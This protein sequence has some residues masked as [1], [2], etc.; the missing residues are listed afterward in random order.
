MENQWTASNRYESAAK[1]KLKNYK[2]VDDEGK[3]HKLFEEAKSGKNKGKLTIGGK[4]DKGTFGK[5]WKRI[6]NG[7]IKIQ[8]IKDENLQTAL[9]QAM[10]LYNKALDASDAVIELRN[11]IRE[12]AQQKLDNIIDDYTHLTDFV[13]SEHDLTEANITLLEKQTGF[14]KRNGKVAKDIE[15]QKVKYYQ[16]QAEYQNE[17]IALRRGEL[18]DYKA[19]IK[20]QLKS[21]EMR[22]GDESWVDAQKHMK[23]LNTEIANAK[24]NIADLNTKIRESNWSNFQNAI[25]ILEHLDNQLNSTIGLFSDLEAFSK[26]GK[27]NNNG[28]NQINVNAQLMANAREEVA[29]YT[30]AIKKLKTELKNQTITQAEYDEEMRDYTEK[31]LAAVTSV[32]KYRD[33]IIDLIKNGL[34]K[35]IEAFSEL[36]SKRKEDLQRQKDANDYAKNVRDQTKN[37]NKLRQQISALSGDTTQATQARI[38]QLQAQLAEQEENLIETRKDHEYDVFTK[39]LDDEDKAFKESQEDRIRELETSLQAQDKAIKDALQ[40]T[41]TDYSTTYSFLKQLSEEYGIKLESDITNPWKNAK[42]AAEEYERSVN[43]IAESES[44]IKTGGQVKNTG[45]TKQ[46]GLKLTKNQT[47]SKDQNILA[48]NNYTGSSKNKPKGATAKQIAEATQKFYNK[49]STKD[50][51]INSS[52]GSQSKNGGK[53]GT[54]TGASNQKAVVDG[55]KNLKIALEKAQ[56]TYNNSDAELKKIQHNIENASV[57]MANTN[58]QREREKFQQIIDE[59]RIRLAGV[60]EKRDRDKAALNA[61]QSKFNN[62][63]NQLSAVKDINAKISSAKEAKKAAQSTYDTAN[64]TYKDL[65]DQY[66]SAMAKAAKAKGAKKSRLLASAGQIKKDLDAAKSQRSS[67]KKALNA[68]ISDL[69]KLNIQKG[70][71]INKALGLPTTDDIKVAVEEG[72]AALQHQLE[73]ES[74]PTKRSEIITAI[75]TVASNIINEMKSMTLTSKSGGGSS[76][77]SNKTGNSTGGNQTKSN[78]TANTL[79]GIIN[80]G[81]KHGKTLTAAE[82]KNSALWKYIVQNYQRTPTTAMYRSLAKALGVSVPSTGNLNAKQRSAILTKLKKAG[83]KS[84]SKSVTRPGVYLTDEQGLGTEAIITKSG[85][86]RQLGEGTMVFNKQQKETLWEMSKL[87]AQDLY[88]KMGEHTVPH[89]NVTTIAPS[90][91]CHYD[92]LLTVNGNVDKD[93]LPGLKDLLKMSYEYTAKNMKNEFVKL[94]AR[95]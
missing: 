28:I 29:D 66:N 14:Q 80:K 10:D 24:V 60:Q 65:A 1:S 43:K 12:L 61:A 36:I 9:N 75:N 78:T 23:E 21:G 40:S 5:Y 91:N 38:K 22:V 52:R 76:S 47:G 62:K 18:K 16:Q 19:Q 81:K 70:D 90:V 26:E 46:E 79:K 72:T 84:G 11:S 92:S 54:N 6:Q 41:M 69:D 50:V 32:K 2:Y 13:Q 48:E 59:N 37:I 89:D 7:S 64:K 77:S 27:I 17:L 33:A 55:L 42:N 88:A 86:L 74:D 45:E 51:I 30:E 49:L 20:A 67:A 31:Q 39:G 58:K 4:G 57:Q 71:A 87:S 95:H 73:Q 93:A 63:A 3:T 83:L 35:E 85:V 8:E 44:L 94:G 25:A 56:N 53:G 34:Q 68:A 15:G 82:K